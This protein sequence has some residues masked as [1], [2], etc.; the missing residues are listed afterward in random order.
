LGLRDQSSIK[1]IGKSYDFL[2]QT[3]NIDFVYLSVYDIDP[4]TSQ[5]IPK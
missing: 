3:H 1:I 5:N 4:T 2:D